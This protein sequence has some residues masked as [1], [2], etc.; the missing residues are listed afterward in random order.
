[1]LPLKGGPQ[2]LSHF[3]KIG[4]LKRDLKMVKI[5]VYEEIIISGSINQLLCIDCMYPL[6]FYFRFTATERSPQPTTADE[7]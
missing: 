6:V 5:E 7:T 4:G 3:Q 1:M 2:L